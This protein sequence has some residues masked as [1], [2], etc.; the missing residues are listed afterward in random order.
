[1]ARLVACV[2]SE[3]LPLLALLAW[4]QPA[5]AQQTAGPGQ[6]AW[7]PVSLDLRKVA[8]GSWAEYSTTYVG[9]KTRVTERLGLVARTG[10]GVDIE[11]ESPEM[12]EVP[13]GHRTL[14]TRLSISDTEIKVVE[15]RDDLEAPPAFRRPDPKTRIGLES[16]T[17]PAGVFPKAEHYRIRFQGQE[18]MDFWTSPDAPPLGLVKVV[19]KGCTGMFSGSTKELIA[20]GTGA[21]R[22]AR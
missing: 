13:R 19:I 20:R 2:V 4:I 14:R 12:D 18:T 1:M 15:P 9:M 10:A 17:V 6:G 5:A 8:V 7:L 3:A 16:V 21:K 11:S 22:S